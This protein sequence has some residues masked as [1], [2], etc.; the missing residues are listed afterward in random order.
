MAPLP[1]IHANLFK[2]QRSSTTSAT[3]DFLL[4]LVFYPL[5]QNLLDSFLKGKRRLPSQF[6]YDFGGIK[7]YGIL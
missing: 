7:D 3:K 6:F 4:L 1:K 2:G 5:L